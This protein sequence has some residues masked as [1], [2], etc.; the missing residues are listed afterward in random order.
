MQWLWSPC[1]RINQGDQGWWGV[2]L[3]RVIPF[4]GS[5]GIRK[6][7]KSVQRRVEPRLPLSAHFSWCWVSWRGKKWL[8][9]IVVGMRETGREVSFSHIFRRKATTKW[10]E[11][12][13]PLVSLFGVT[14]KS[15][16]G[17]LASVFVF[18]ISIIFFFPFEALWKERARD[19]RVN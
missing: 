10:T 19:R 5:T 16:L 15:W 9:A 6:R 13:G 4:S 3:W 8:K 18:C 17:P 11:G 14:K 7:W 2:P 12:S 1:S